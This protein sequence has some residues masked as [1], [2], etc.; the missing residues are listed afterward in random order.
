[1]FLQIY[2]SFF[3]KEA[4]ELEVDK[5]QKL[6]NIG[7]YRR[8]VIEEMSITVES[9]ITYWLLNGRMCRQQDLSFETRLRI[10]FMYELKDVNC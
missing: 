8:R 5:I 10:C 4:R 1:M 2:I 7:S 9:A 6:A 3:L